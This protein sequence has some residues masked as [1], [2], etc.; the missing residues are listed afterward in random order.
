MKKTLLWIFAFIITIVFAYYQRATG[1]TYPLKI[2]YNQDGVKVE[3]HLLRSG[4]TTEDAKIEIS[5]EPKDL[6]ATLYYKRFKTND[7]FTPIPME[8]KGNELYAFLPKQPAAGK[9]EYYIQISHNGKVV[10]LPAEH[11][12]IRFKGSIPL[13]ILI[14]HVIFM[15]TAFFLSMR[16]GLEYFNKEPNVIP[17]L[18]W[19]LITLVIGGFI[20]GPIVQYYAFGAFWTGFPFGHDLTDNKTAIAIIGWLWAYY[21]IRKG[22]EPRKWA[23]IGSVIL[24]LVYLIPHSVLGSELKY[25]D[26]DST[27]TVSEK[28]IT[29]N[30]GR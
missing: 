30:Q 16:T 13:G 19:T 20:L 26:S 12:V 9:L 8:R 6:Q 14:A 3:G 1:P 2:N 11:T 4:Y 22:A 5:A 18:K 24:I 25:N 27:K 10:K 21:K 15:F 23:L 28:V 17:L 29:N 7:K